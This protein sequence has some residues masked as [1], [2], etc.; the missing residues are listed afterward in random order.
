MKKIKWKLDYFEIPE[1]IVKIIV[2]QLPLINEISREKKLVFYSNSNYWMKQSHYN[3]MSKK[4]WPTATL[5]VS[6][7]IR[8]A[9]TSFTYSMCGYV[10]L[11]SN[12]FD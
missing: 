8:R 12:M 6:Y 5:K 1:R 7:Y 10:I 2:Q 4:S 11:R 9:K 3:C